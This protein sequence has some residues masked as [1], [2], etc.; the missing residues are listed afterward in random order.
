MILCTIN[1]NAQN[2]LIYF[3]GT[4]ASTNVESVKVENLT[5]GTSL[6]MNGTDI[7]RLMVITTGVNAIDDNQSSELKIFPNPMSGSSVVQTYPKKDGN[8]V[9]TISD[10]NGKLLARN[11]SFLKTGLQ[12]FSIKGL[13]SGFYLINVIGYG[14]KYSGKILSNSDSNGT[15]AIEKLSNTLSV[16]NIQVKKTDS[17]GIQGTVDMS[18]TNGDRIK[19]T[20]ISGNY[21]TVKT[22][23]P[24]ADKTITFNSYN[25]QMAII[26]IILW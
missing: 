4:G 9:I 5:A 18:Y 26:T 22:D 1:T 20:G 19:F 25:A 10:I 7:L 13:N 3:A 2:Y 11:E 15:I 16:E 21:S 6:V 23:V 14:Y 24:I 17:K 8:T 12:E